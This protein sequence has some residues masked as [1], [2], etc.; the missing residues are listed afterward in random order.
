M[1]RNSVSPVNFCGC[2]RALARRALTII[3][4]GTLTLGPVFAQAATTGSFTLVGSTK[5]FRR[6]HTATLLLN[7]NVLVAAGAPLLPAATSEFTIRS[8]PPGPTPAR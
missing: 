3:V 7:G 1:N 6:Q 2:A 5:Q 8:P 4:L